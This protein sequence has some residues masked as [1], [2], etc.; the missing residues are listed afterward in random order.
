VNPLLPIIRKRTFLNT[1]RFRL[2]DNASEPNAKVL[3][4]A[5][6]WLEVSEGTNACQAWASRDLLRAPSTVGR[7]TPFLS[8]GTLALPTAFGFDPHRH[9]VY[10]HQHL[11]LE[12]APTASTALTVAYVGSYAL[13]LRGVRNINLIDSETGTRP[14]P[15]FS[16]VNI[17]AHYGQATHNAL[18]LTL[19]QR[20]S[21]RLQG[22][23]SYTWAH[24]ID[25]APD[26]ALGAAD[27][28]DYNKLRAE[29]SNGSY[30]IRHAACYELLYD[31][32]IGAF[33]THQV[34]KRT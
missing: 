9:D 19:K 3:E 15:G 26:S 11:T 8:Q 4:I 27:P 18:Q 7:L 16:N 12:Y 29:R 25:N 1:G 30:D 31:L 33:E 14:I 21:H 24:A 6:G 22:A 34:W 17:D 13:D 28:Q 5:V 2:V 10:A 23:I 32:P 20:Y